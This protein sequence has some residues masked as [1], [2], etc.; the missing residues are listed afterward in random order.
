[1]PSRSTWSWLAPLLVL[2]IATAARLWDL[3]NPHSLVFDET[4]Y[5]KDS[6]TL[7]NNGYESTWLAD[8]DKAF[9]SGDTSL[10]TKTGSFVVH[11]ELGKWLIA[12]GMGAFGA[13]NAVGWRIAVA[14]AG[15]LIVALIMLVA[16]RLTGSLALATIAGFLMAIDGHAI[17][18]SRVGLLDNFVTLFSLLGFLFIVMDRQNNLPRLLAWVNT[19]RRDQPD[20]EPTWGPTLWARPY[21]LL[22]GLAF[23]LAIS[24]KWSGLYF[25]AAF[26]VYVVVMDALD[27]RR[28][29]LPFWF[30]AAVLKQ[31]PATFLLMV[32]VAAVTYLASWTSWILTAGGYDRQ[33][34]ADNPSL[35]WTGLFSWLPDWFQSL[36]A[37]HLTAYNFHVSLATPHSYQANPLTWLFMTRPTSMYYVGDHNGQNGCTF[38]SCASAITAIANPLIWWAGSAAILYLVYRLLRFREWQVGIILMGMVAGYL[39]WLMY[40]NRTVF[41]FY[42]IV[43]EPYMVLALTFVFGI[44]LGKPT[45]D[46]ERRLAGRRW[47]IVFLVLASLISIFFFPLW[48]GMQIP[49]WYWQIHM[50]LPGWI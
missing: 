17:V 38:D 27:R 29:G 6:W 39:P 40:L 16:K 8:A 22:A 21:L 26:A 31:A 5:V 4:F 14:L 11:P 2:V 50:W 18:L 20:N 41:Q 43:Y 7:W 35:R 44:W 25:L 24:I 32:P 46:L 47:V 23:G 10:F 19:R 36:W 3:G 48:T 13:G 30:S 9:N 42:G 45:D 34:V 28:V 12:L 33:L 15:I 49:H 1:M 37:Y